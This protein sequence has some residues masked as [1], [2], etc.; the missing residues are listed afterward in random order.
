MVHV[1]T[2][3][4]LVI[5]EIDKIVPSS[6]CERLSLMLAS[7]IGK[8]RPLP[9]DVPQ[10]V[11]E[12]IL[13]EACA[14]ADGYSVKILYINKADDLYDA[15]V[16]LS[17]E[18]GMKY[19]EVIVGGSA[20]KSKEIEPNI[21]NESSQE[22]VIEEFDVPRQSHQHLA[23]VL[24][25][26]ETST[27]ELEL[28]T[29]T[30]YVVYKLSGIEGKNIFGIVLWR[31]IAAGYFHVDYGVEVF[32]VADDSSVYANGLLGWS[33]DYFSHNA[34]WTYLIGEVY[35]N[36]GFSG[37]FQQVNAWTWAAVDRYLNDYDDAGTY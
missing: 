32:Y 24:K 23:K 30:I 14:Y 11:R 1:E 17:K 35:A 2:S 8:E 29:T 34:Q 22:E 33:V 20:T 10:A 12:R 27:Y 9:A 37:P 28:E 4:D 16:L 25:R 21:V 31:L 7:E 5:T 3:S 36:A 19:L 15:L 13:D 6:D 18:N 26:V